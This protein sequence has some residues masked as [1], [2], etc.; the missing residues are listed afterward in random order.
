[1]Q[2]QIVRRR[3][4]TVGEQ[5]E[6]ITHGP[7]RLSTCRSRSSCEYVIGRPLSP[8]ISMRIRAPLTLMPRYASYFTAY[9]LRF[10]PDSVTAVCACPV[11]KTTVSKQCFEFFELHVEVA[12]FRSGGQYAPC[13]Y[14]RV[15]TPPPSGCR[16][17]ALAQ[18]HALPL[19]LLRTL[20][21]VQL[22]TVSRLT[23]GGLR[24]LQVAR[25]LH[26]LN[27]D[28]AQLAHQ[29]HMNGDW[30]TAFQRYSFQSE[31]HAQVPPCRDPPGA[32]TP[33]YC[34]SMKLQNAVAICCLS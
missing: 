34:V 6:S 9:D 13:M 5:E 20:P 24:L 18:H 14:T 32:C 27:I 31:L 12:C 21:S 15:G 8:V 16:M 30:E 19:A 17:L 7:L 1:M 29:S 33:C 10:I 11:V 2:R 23:C 25:L 4:W 3:S 28:P 26:S 22:P